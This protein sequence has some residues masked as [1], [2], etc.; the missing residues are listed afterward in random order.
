MTSWKK[1]SDNTTISNSNDILASPLWYNPKI[2]KIEL[3]LPNWSK[4]G[5]TYVGDLLDSNGFF[6]SQKDLEQKYTLLKTNFLEYLRVKMCVEPY[7]KKYSDNTRLFFYQPCLP[8]QIASLF[9]HNQGSK[10][11]YKLL[12]KTCPEMSFKNAWNNELNINIDEDIWQKAFKIC[13]KLIQDNNLIWFQYRILHR[14]LGTHKL[15]SKIGKTPT[16]ECL[17]CKSHPESIIHLFSLCPYTINFWDRVKVWIQTRTGV[18]LN[19][20]PLEHI[21]GYLKTDNFLPINVIILAVKTYIFSNSRM[22]RNLNIMELKQKIKVIY[23]EQK[24]VAKMD[25]NEEVFFKKWQFI[26]VLLH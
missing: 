13:F 16:S 5:I 26:E 6:I 21:L 18:T 14:I 9:G 3:N 15:L 12:N 1:L 11:F 24:L 25:L 8:I 2:S 20:G 23:D 7:L 19:L 10:H 22:S 17:L 4:H